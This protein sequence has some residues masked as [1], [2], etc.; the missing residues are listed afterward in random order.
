MIDIK[1][2]VADDHQL[3]RD[4]VAMT[5]N[6]LPDAR[7]IAEVSNG[8]EVLAYVK[9]ELPD[10]ILMDIKMPQL[11]GIETTKQIT[12][13][14]PSIRVI[15][16]TLFGEERYLEKMLEAG[17][18]GFLLK[19]IGRQGLH[20]AIQLVSDGKEYYS[21]E[22]IPYFTKKYLAKD[23]KAKSLTKREME[24]LQM[25]AQGMTNNEIADKLFISL[26]TVA[27]HRANILA[28][29]ESRN[30]VTLLSYAIKNDLVSI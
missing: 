15:A 18:K 22:L 6:K 9:Q 5:V 11:D 27:N 4:G 7:V 19:N 2:L 14:Y 3:F 16:L 24:V 1:V 21:E 12:E 23:E 8:L 20:K 10:I 26:R 25:I 29:T 17:A 28:K 13:E 30:T